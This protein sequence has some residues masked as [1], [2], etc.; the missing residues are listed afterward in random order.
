M[1]NFSATL[2]HSERSGDEL[3]KIQTWHLND[4]P[5]NLNVNS[6]EAASELARTE[7][8]AEK[9]DPVTHANES[10]QVSEIRTHTA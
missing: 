6:A 9:I 10:Y 4:Y 1:I 8:K 7:E 3:G 5:H 2:G